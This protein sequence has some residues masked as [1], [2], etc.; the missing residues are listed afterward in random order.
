MRIGLLATLA[1]SV[2]V[3][4]GSCLP[5]IDDTPPPIEPNNKLAIAITLPDSALTALQGEEVEIR[6]AGSNL[7]GEDAKVSLL[8]ESRRNLAMSTLVTEIPF[9]GTGD[10]GEFDWDTQDFEGPYTL[11]A[12]IE[13][14]SYFHEDRATEEIT[15]DAAPVFEFRGPETFTQIERGTDTVT[16][17]W[18]SGDD[19]GGT[20]RIGIDPDEDHLTGNEEFIAEPNLPDPAEVNS[21]IWSGTLINGAPAAAGTYNLFALVNDDVHAELTVEGLAQIKIVDPNEPGG[22]EVLKPDEDGSFTDADVAAMDYPVIEYR[23][24]R[25]DKVLVDVRIDIDD[26]R[27]NGNEITID[28][29]RAVEGGTEPD[30]FEWDGTDSD[31]APVDYGMYR[32]FISVSG[33]SGVPQTYQSEGLI[34][35]RETELTPMVALL[36]PANPVTVKQGGNV[37]ISWRDDD[38]SEAA[39]VRIFID[40]D[41]T[42]NEGEPPGNPDDI[43]EIEILDNPRD[44]APDGVDDVFNWTVESGIEPGEYYVFAY[45]DDGGSGYISVAA[46]TVTVE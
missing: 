13:T 41:D 21:I 27:T 6:W 33:E 29:Q 1:V 36:S 34:I 39:T 38:P 8:L 2:A 40:D 43:E 44:A 46:G 32:V 7:T 19:V 26:V 15:V 18:F 3:L 42:P 37:R 28:A 12:R 9:E 16:I 25:E 10:D 30:P 4:G 11:I 20:A 14:A 22:T 45:I 31:G 23:I 24:N 17:S 5:L 35:R